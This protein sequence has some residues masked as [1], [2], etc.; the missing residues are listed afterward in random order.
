MTRDDVFRDLAG[1]LERVDANVDTAR[2]A[3]DDRPFSTFGINSMSLVRLVG[4]VE[5][6]FSIELEDSDVLLAYSFERLVALILDRLRAGSGDQAGSP[7]RVN[8]LDVLQRNAVRAGERAEVRRRLARQDDVA[9]SLDRLLR[10]AAHVG[11]GIPEPL[12]SRP[13]VVLVAAT[14]PLTALTGF[15]AALS[16]EALP[17]MLAHPKAL[18]GMDAYLARITWLARHFGN[19]PVVAMEPGLLP[20]RAALDGLPIV[21]LPADVTAVQ[22]HALPEPS[23]RHNGGDDVAFLQLTSASTGDAKLVAVTHA[24]VCANLDAMTAGLELS[25]GQDLACSWMPL[26]HD[27][28]LIGATLFPMYNGVSTIMMRPND[29]IK[30]PAFWIRT[31]AEFRATFTGAPNFAIDYAANAVTDADLEGVDLSSMRRFGLAAEPIHRT[32]VQRWLD[33]FGPYGFRA[34]AFVPGLGMAEST[35][36]TTF[37]V[38]R[39]PRYLFVETDGAVVGQPVRVL[40]RG[41]CTHPARPVPELPDGARA[42]AVLSLG[43]ALEGITVDLRDAEGALVEG[44][45][46]VG[47]ICVRGAS[48]AGYYD[49]D[50]GTAR[51]VPDGVLRSGDLGFVDSGELFVL[52]RIKNVIIRNGVNY[53]ASLLEQQVADVLGVLAHGVAIL[54]EDIHDPASPVHV[55]VELADGLP[56]LSVEQRAAL[57]QLDLAVDVVTFARGLALPRTTSGKKRYHVCRQLLV[58]ADLD[59]VERF[60]LR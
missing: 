56:A 12:D 35:L 9:L 17:L 46:R 40:G 14:D 52:E 29:F 3:L 5:R 55:V 21:E 42:V 48:V 10:A 32:T 60:D 51:P 22:A 16:V 58:S 24:N 11:Q 15:L 23:S 4:E 34:D 30:N 31:M 26:H 50:A 37:R 20:D 33:R 38:G 49:A 1:L 59:T 28:G 45:H 19:R 7:T 2:L 36:S 41:E 54:E 8:V 47:E 25:L 53:L 18:G 6:T 57:R 27:M 13:Q 43:S 39:P 44:E